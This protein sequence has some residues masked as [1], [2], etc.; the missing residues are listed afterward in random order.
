MYTMDP[1]SKTRAD[2]PQYVSSME[3]CVFLDLLNEFLYWSV[4]DYT[5][6][7]AYTNRLR[8]K[9]CPTIIYERVLL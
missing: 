9:F 4:M 6:L 8:H 1:S 5:C 7:F 3:Q 2:S